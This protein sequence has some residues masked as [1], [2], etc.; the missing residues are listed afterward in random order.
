M[1]FAVGG[2][3]EVDQ[4]DAVVAELGLT[5]VPFTNVYNGCATAGSALA[6]ASQLIQ[7]GEYEVGLVAGHGQAHPAP[8][9]P[10]PTSTPAHPGTARW[11]CS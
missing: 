2:S 3:Y 11:A 6:L 5:G 9:P 1:Q 7:L 4:P 8:S 10:S